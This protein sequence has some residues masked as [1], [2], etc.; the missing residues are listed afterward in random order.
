M[1]TDLRAVSVREALGTTSR[2]TY[3]RAPLPRWRRS[4]R[5]AG[6]PGVVPAP[7]PLAVINDGDSSISLR[8]AAH[9]GDLAAA[10]ELVS[11]AYTS[12]GYRPV[13]HETF[14]TGRLTIL[15]ERRPTAVGSAPAVGSTT[16][17][18]TCTVVVDGCGSL[19]LE[20]AC[21]AEVQRVRDL[22]GRLAE[23][24]GLAFDDTVNNLSVLPRVFEIGWVFANVI[25]GATHLLIEVNPRHVS[26]Y[27]RALGFSVAGETRED[28]R[29]D[30]PGVPMILDAVRAERLAERN[31]GLYRH[32]D[33]QRWAEVRNTLASADELRP[34]SA[35][36]LP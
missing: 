3:R 12:R 22:G 24:T 25:M 11:R 9:E 8:A 19:G 27:R 4:S 18:G 6:R 10:A 35:G 1:A 23:Y 21:G 28:P 29:V 2:D 31:A 26:F 15:A 33:R 7:R 5:S 32:F 14:G 34:A 16:V 13:L 20:S 17:V 36:P 30:A